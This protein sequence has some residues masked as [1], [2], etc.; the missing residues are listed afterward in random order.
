MYMLIFINKKSC[1]LFRQKVEHYNVIP[2][3]VIFDNANKKKE[4]LFTKLTSDSTEEY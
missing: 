4:V 1:L 2:K 3:R